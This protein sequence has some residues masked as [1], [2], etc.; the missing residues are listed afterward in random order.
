MGSLPNLDAK[1]FPY[2]DIRPAFDRYAAGPSETGEAMADQLLQFLPRASLRDRDHQF[3]LPRRQLQ[4]PLAL[5]GASRTPA[6]L[7][8][9]V[10]TGS[11][12]ALD[13]F[14]QLGVRG[15]TRHARNVSNWRTA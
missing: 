9:C 14:D 8:T 11:G 3:P 1:T 4:N 13:H 7:L 10:A 15:T 6:L 12:L 5:R 2:S